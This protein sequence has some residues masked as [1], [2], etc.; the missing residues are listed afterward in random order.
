MYD[1][2]DLTSASQ[3]PPDL[4]G[5]DFN[6]YN[7]VFG[8]RANQRISGR[9]VKALKARVALLAASP[10][11]ANN[12]ATLWQKAADYAGAVINSNGGIAG[13]DPNGHKFYDATRIDAIN[14][15]SKIDQKEMFWRRAI[16]TSNSRESQNFP[17]SLYGNG[18]VNPTQNL[19]DAFPAL[20]GY[21]ITDPLSLYNPANPYA[22]RDPRPALYIVY[23][24]N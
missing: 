11:F 1:Y 9:I 22:N 16:V 3:F 20:H 24:G 18:F 10:A 6:D 5:M 4:S 19:V 15:A 8:L 23:N 7:S 12:D 14:L 13:L 21:P 17:P 2:V